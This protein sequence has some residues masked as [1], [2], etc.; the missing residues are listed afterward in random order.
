MRRRNR[1]HLLRE[2]ATL[3][4]WISLVLAVI[5]YT[6][7]KWVFP[8]FAGRNVLFKGI[9]EALGNNAAFFS[10]PFLVVTLIAAFNAFRR[11]KLLDDQTGLDSLKTVSWQDFELLVGE[12]FRRQGFVVEESGGSAPDGGVDLVLLRSGKKTVV[13]CKRWKNAQVGVTLI[14]ELYG[15][16]VAERADRCVFVSSGTFTAEAIAFAE[17]KPIDLINGR[18]FA[19]LVKV[20]QP[21]GKATAPQHL[22]AT[23]VPVCPTCGGSMVRRVA[24][25]GAQAGSE[26]WGCPRFPEC[27]GT[28]GL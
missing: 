20:L 16:M 14:R 11:R 4:W 18:G 5:V 19:E 1:P 8:A 28:R 7:L 22:V 6:A 12:A 27:R 10:A 13:Q 23:S 25:R 21:A 2:L 3:P 26:F 15:V 9:A 17:G 24:K